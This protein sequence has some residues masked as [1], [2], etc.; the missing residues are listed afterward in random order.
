MTEPTRTELFHQP[1]VAR[2]P[3]PAANEVLPAADFAE[4]ARRWSALGVHLSLW[5]A[6]GTQSSAPVEG[7]RFWNALWSAGSAIGQV[8][9]ESVRAAAA[10]TPVGAAVHQ[11]DRSSA[12]SSGVPAGASRF[13]AYWPDVGLWVSPVRRRGR[14]RGFVAAVIRSGDMDGEGARRLWSRCGVDGAL[15]VR[16]SAGQATV[17]PDRL[18]AQLG[19]LTLGIDQLEQIDKG[20]E[21]LGSLTGNLEST[22]EELGL[23]YRISD[24]M[25]I[26]QRPGQMLQRI[27]RQLLLVSRAAA[28]AF[29]LPDHLKTRPSAQAEAA[30]LESILSDRIVQVGRGAPN[31]TALEQLERDLRAHFDMAGSHLLLNDAGAESKLSWTTGWLRHLVAIPLVHNRRHLGLMLAINCQDSADFNSIDVQLLRAVG[32]RVTAFLENQRLYD[33][34][35]DLLMGLLHAMISSIDAKDPY[36]C[37]HSERV[38]YLSRRIAEVNGQPANECQRVYLSGLLHDVGKIGIPDAILTK[39]GKLTEQE[40]DE[41]KK[42]PAIGA[43]ILSRVTQI[44]DLLPGVLYHHERMDGRGY[45]SGLSGAEIPL[46]GRIVCLADCFDAMTTSRTY[47]SA[48]PLPM[49]VA[50]IRRCAGSQFDPQLASALL[51]LDLAKTMEEAH[52]F[53]HDTV[54]LSQV[55]VFTEMTMPQLSGLEAA[56]EILNVSA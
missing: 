31:L 22:Y 11:Q 44:Q 50:E 32:D 4:L 8:V 52:A 9:G 30:V 28:V 40:F 13:G 26:P 29:V 21:E 54:Q 51:K 43:R 37:G 47:R 12:E 38:A 6:D 39:P 49:A 46:L 14:V 7:D 33:D 10:M 35:A 1:G 48:L 42:H 34:L 5:N 27:G 19:L 53:S 55:G 24:E 15:M 18:D 56:R 45:P 3:A 41:L 25:G 17:P 23:I 36:T 20:R 16:L 2:L